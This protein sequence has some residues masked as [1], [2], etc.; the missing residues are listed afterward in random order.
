MA[1]E[2]LVQ[3]VPGSEAEVGAHNEREADPET[4]KTDVQ[5]QQTHR[6]G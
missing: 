3:H 6:G 5:P 2:A 4:H 1:G